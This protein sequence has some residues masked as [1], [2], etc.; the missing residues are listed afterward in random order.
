MVKHEFGGDWTNEKLSC[1]QEYLVS[2]T[3]IFHKNIHAKKLTTTYVDA[4]AGTG[5]RVPSRPQ[6]EHQ[7]PSLFALEDPDTEAYLKGSARIALEVEPSFNHYLFIDKN[8]QHVLELNR[9][10]EQFFHKS[11]HINI[12]LAEANAFLRDWC[13]RVDWRF[14]RAVVFLDPYGM[15]VEW[16]LIK[17]I[18]QTKAIDLWLLFPLGI[19]VNRLLKKDE[20][21]E[22]EWANALTRIFGTDEWRSAFY[23]QQKI[24][25]LFGEEDIQCKNA[26][27]DQ[28]GRFFV[29]RLKTVFAGVAESALQLCNSKNNP[30]YLLCFAAGNPKGAPT[31]VKIA[32][33]IIEKKR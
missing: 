33:Y 10:K 29:D 30:I 18:A 14:N 3:T 32:K 28:I 6:P 22:Q 1:L 16:D 2:Y 20:P 12:E 26:E 25:T 13:S 21:P 17:I 27:L 7:P 5:Y 23:S 19:A 9:L 4:F 31:A 15:Q 24:L 11:S 8:P